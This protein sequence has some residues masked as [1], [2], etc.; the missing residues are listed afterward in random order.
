MKVKSRIV[1]DTNVLI[2]R[3]LLPHSDAAKVTHH[4]VTNCVPIATKATLEELVRVVQKNKFDR[5]L[6]LGEREDFINEYVSV[7]ELWA[8]VDALYV[9]R[10]LSDNKFL[11][12]AVQAQADSIV[13]GDNDLL[14]LHPF[15]GIDILSPNE[16]LLRRMTT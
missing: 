11:D 3:L 9:C 6:T 4:I 2:S 8:V 1:I 13:T 14:V 5:Y 7:T 16:F 10:D 15:M 12:L